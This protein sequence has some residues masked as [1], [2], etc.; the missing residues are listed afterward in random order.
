MSKR[1]DQGN[2]TRERLLDVATKLFVERGY[3]D[4]P[5]PAVLEAADVSRGALY[6][7]FESKEDLFSAVLERV[8]S[9][10]VE[11]IRDAAIPQD[12]P[13]AQLHAGCGL[14]LRRAAN[15]PAVQR[16][17]LLEAPRVLAWEQWRAYDEQF[18][19]GGLKVSLGHLAQ[20]GRLAPALVDTLAHM[21]LAAL[22]EAAILIA[23]AEH[24][25]I[26]L[27]QAQAS[28]ELLLDRLFPA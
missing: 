3:D 8:E 20:Q 2:A 12:D 10:L 13:L 26:A 17:V 23:T 6:H 16:I 4:T 19:L 7:H 11:Q 27:R 15:D 18:G 9:E 1:I 5:I 28:V 22:D 24:P 25:R 21:L 14:F